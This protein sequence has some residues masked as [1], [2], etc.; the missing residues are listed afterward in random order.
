MAENPG[1]KT[2]FNWEILEEGVLG[3]IL[4]VYMKIWL[5]FALECKLLCCFG[6]HEETT[7]AQFMKSEENL[8]KFQIFST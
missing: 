2:Q 4:C 6:Q 3:K 7:F 1:V 5:S 8:S